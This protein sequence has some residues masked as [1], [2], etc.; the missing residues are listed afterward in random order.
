MIDITNNIEL[1]LLSHHRFMKNATTTSAFTTA[2]PIATTTFHGAGI[3]THVT[4]TVKK[5]SKKRD[6]PM[7]H[8]N[9]AEEI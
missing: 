8:K 7:V 6:D 9:L 3:S 4:A 5:V 1:N 2:I